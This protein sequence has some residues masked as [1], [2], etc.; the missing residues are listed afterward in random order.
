MLLDDR[1][2]G[3][4]SVE[5]NMPNGFTAAH[6]HTLTAIAGVAAITVEEAARYVR[7]EKRY[8]RVERVQTV[9]RA[10]NSQLHMQALLNLIVE[11]AAAIFGVPAASVMLL[12]ADSETLY[13]SAA[14]GLS[15]AYQQLRRVPLHEVS[16]PTAPASDRPAYYPDL[17]AVAGEQAE[18]V[19]REDLRTML[20]IPLMRG[21]MRLGSLNLYTRGAPRAPS[22]PTRWRS[23]RCSPARSPSPSTTCACSTRW[24]CTPRRRRW[25]TA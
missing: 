25:R 19:A 4:L 3:V 22:T 2:V 7:V 23:R 14:Y 20:A 6:L 12:E 17:R 10:I 16:D 21:G 11:E 24:N 5:S 18:L 8:R 15:V 13:T 1:L 9:I